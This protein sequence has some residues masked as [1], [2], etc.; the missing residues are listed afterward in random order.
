MEKPKL[1][2]I[3][4]AF[5]EELIIEKT[6]TSL[7]S[8]NTTA[9]FEVIVVD[10][11]ST[12]KTS[13]VVNNFSKKHPNF[14]VVFE[15]RPGIGR[16]RR[17]GHAA[18]QGSIMVGTDA[19]VLHPKDWLSRIVA[20]FEK[21]PKIVGLVG[22]YVFYDTTELT[23]FFFHINMVVTDTISR[24]I[25]GTYAFRGNNFAVTSEAYHKSG[26]FDPN[27][28]ALED[29]DLAIRVAKYGKIIYRPSLMI[30]MTARRFRG[31]LVQQT[32]KRLRAFYYRAIKRDNTKAT[33]WDTIR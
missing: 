8:Q 32:I 13:E 17:T 25:T 24:L 10:N 6:L 4:P 30:R 15:K 2:V 31:H 3:I 22:N 18:A 7:A 9:P 33:G 12:D 28:S 11:N 5:N 14:R 19:D 1:S 21:N 26:G 20:E 29:L 27:V 16:A 23:N